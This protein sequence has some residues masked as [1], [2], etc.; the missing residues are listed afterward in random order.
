M[1]DAA[2]LIVLVAAA[3]A[4]DPTTHAMARATRDALGPTARVIVRET[5]GDP[6]DA[7]AIAAERA[8]NAD[9]VVE[10]SWVASREGRH[11]QASVRVHLRGGRWIDRWITFRPTDADAE[12]GRTLGF[13]IASILPDASS[14]AA[15]AAPGPSPP[16][17]A[18]GTPP[19]AAGGP[20]P[21]EST[22]PAE[23]APAPASSPAPSPPPAAQPAPAPSPPPPSPGP[24][25]TLRP[26]EAGAHPPDETT[27]L[28][29][30]EVLVNF[31]GGGGGGA[32][33]GPA[34]EYFV[35][36]QLSL[37]VGG[38]LRRGMLTFPDSIDYN[39]WSIV[40]GVVYHPLRARLSERVGFSIRADF[41][42]DI[43]QMSRSQ[44]GAN[45]GP[46]QAQTKGD[47]GPELAADVALLAVPNFEVVL[48]GGA[49]AWIPSITISE[50]A[51]RQVVWQY[52]GF[53]ETGF[54]LRF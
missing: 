24:P 17:V 19:A 8:E 44:S 38:N 50:G 1:A 49:Q 35:L 28:L 20:A 32:G 10:L 30:A 48:G 31:A 43:V 6:G 54:R 45:P 46:P 21:P 34:V 13:A 3:E 40:G 5:P 33:V 27:S 12:R 37:R 4:T 47:Y 15:H 51:D 41:V 9:A 2:T 39:I 18:S 11:R 29:T 52:R 7:D 23:P 26:S 25:P 53:A 22:P 14:G 16:P 36:P 42:V